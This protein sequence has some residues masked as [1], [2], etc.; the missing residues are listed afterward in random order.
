MRDTIASAAFAIPVETLIRRRRRA[1]PP[2][3]L[4]RRT[5]AAGAATERQRTIEAC[6]AELAWARGDVIFIA[7]E[8]G[9]AIDPESRDAIPLH[10]LTRLP[11]ERAAATVLN[12]WGHLQPIESRARDCRRCLNAQRRAGWTDRT[13]GSAR[14]LR[15]HLAERR[16]LKPIFA[17]AVANYRRLRAETLPLGARQSVG[18]E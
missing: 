9:L 4:D 7:G 3:F 2:A 8:L 14:D 5:T 13:A 15:W 11:H 12:V 18:N 10:E 6:R 1:A 17:A 16:K